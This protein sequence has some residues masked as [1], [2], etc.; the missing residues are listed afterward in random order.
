MET[1]EKQVQLQAHRLRD[2]VLPALN[3][4]YV[5]T[6][7]I[8]T[9][10]LWNL[11]GE[12]LFGN[13]LACKVWALYDLLL[14]GCFYWQHKILKN[15]RPSY[16]TDLLFGLVTADTVLAWLQTG[17]YHGGLPTEQPLGTFIF[18]INTAPISAVFFQLMVKLSTK[19]LPFQRRDVGGT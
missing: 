15:R 7:L 5:V 13:P 4:F 16:I 11:D 8:W 12:Q 3:W 17:L 10:I 2:K 14:L 6:L 19:P 9:P 1:L 18:V